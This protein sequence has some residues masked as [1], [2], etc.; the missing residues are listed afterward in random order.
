MSMQTE[1]IS[2]PVSL[3]VEW[4]PVPRV[5]L[6]PPEILQTRRLTTVKH[7][8]AGVFLLVVV[9]GA[10]GTL[11]AQNEVS[12][13]EQALEETR[14]R[15]VALTS[16]KGQFAQVPLVLAEVGAAT[17]AREQALA[18]DVLWHKILDAVSI[19][20]PEEV[21]LTDIEV[22]L[23]AAT[24]TAGADPLL[25]S[26]LGQIDFSGTAESFPAVATWL[27][28][29]ADLP[30]VDGSSLKTAT[31]PSSGE[32]TSLKFTTSVVVIGTALSHR[33]DRKSE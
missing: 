2:L 24:P 6:L 7:R 22:T 10:A 5:N 32:S 23:T 19:I 1:Q 12:Q 21:S 27:D 8:L 28:A 18:Q 30:G 20:T 11:W 4:A 16:A 14:S 13:A 31:R 3:P 25:P 33:Y 9:L 26:G 29:V 15:T 17:T